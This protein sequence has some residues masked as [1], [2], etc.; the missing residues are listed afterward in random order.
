MRSII[1][2]VLKLCDMR[3]CALRLTSPDVNGRL[4]DITKF[5]RQVNLTPHRATINCY[6]GADGRGRD[7]QNGKD[8]PFRT[9]IC[10]RKAKQKEIGIHHFLENCVHL[11]GCEDP[12]VGL[13]GLHLLPPSLFGYS[14]A[15]TGLE[16]VKQL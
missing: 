9:C 1:P 5:V 15:R 7:R 12:L 14:D 16:I 6:T 2:A 3:W 8:H 10:I 4:D 11:G 13:Q